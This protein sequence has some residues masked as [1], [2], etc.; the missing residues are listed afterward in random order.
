M[1]TFKYVLVLLYC[2]GIL[3]GCRTAYPGT[4]QTENDTSATFATQTDSSL[5]TEVL[6]EYKA[7]VSRRLQSDFQQR[8]NNGE[9]IGIPDTV[10]AASSESS[11]K[12][13]WSNMIIEMTSGLTSIREESFDYVLCDINDDTVPELFWVREDHTLLAIFTY[14]Q[15][16]VVLLDAFWPR[17]KGVITQEGLLYTRSSGGAVYTNYVIRSLTSEG[18]WEE[19]ASFG[20]DGYNEGENELCYYET[21]ENIRTIVDRHRFD[22][23][24][25][26]WPFEHGDRWLNT[27][28]P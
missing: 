23:L 6:N 15:D 7:I 1:K 20:T 18:Q 4:P 16:Q 8:W 19:Y 27:L 17:Y 12:E 10:A 2:I 3:S 14:A 13:H 26:Q 9:H 11:L 5:Y 28:V 24:L 25:E 22:T 21:V